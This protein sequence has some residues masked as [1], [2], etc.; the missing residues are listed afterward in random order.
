MT[1]GI[2]GFLELCPLSELAPVWYSN[3]MLLGWVSRTM[4]DIKYTTRNYFE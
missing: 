4:G 1:L 2:T 3:Q